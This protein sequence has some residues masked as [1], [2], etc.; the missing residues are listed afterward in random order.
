MGLGPRLDKKG[1]LELCT[2]VH[3]PL[4]PVDTMREVASG[5]CYLIPFHLRH[6]ELD[7]QMVTD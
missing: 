3:F 7:C 1:E 4:L 6:D 2:H 5:A